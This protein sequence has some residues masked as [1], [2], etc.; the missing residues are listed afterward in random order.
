ML[1][2]NITA[3]EIKKIFQNKENKLEYLK[4]LFNRTG[5]SS[6]IEKT[7]SR[8]DNQIIDTWNY[9]VSV[10]REMFMDTDKYAY[11][12]GC[13]E[14]IDEAIGAWEEKQLGDFEWPFS[15][16]NFDPACASIK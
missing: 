1:T 2:D 10:I 15:A 14:M 8:I 3:V 11:I 6:P 13:R 9:D 7:A 16:M 5:S 12:S 4:R